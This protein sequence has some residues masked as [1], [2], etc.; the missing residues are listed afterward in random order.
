MESCK[1]A[2]APILVVPEL[3]ELLYQSASPLQ[4][5]IGFQNSSRQPLQADSHHA[6]PTIKTAG[7]AAMH[8][9]HVDDNK[10][11]IVQLVNRY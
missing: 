2:G 9:T 8:L 5:D 3:A 1:L 10:H 6:K 11:T 7:G 4:A